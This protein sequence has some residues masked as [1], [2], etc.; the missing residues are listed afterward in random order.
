MW[1]SGN[2][3]SAWASF[4]SFF[5]HVAKLEIDY[6]KWD[7]WERGAIHAGPRIMHKEFCMI[8]DFPESLTVDAQNRPHNDTGP[9]CRWR[10]GSALYALHG[11]NVP[12]WVLETP[13]DQIDPK[14]VL[15]LEN[16]DQRAAIIRHIGVVE[17]LAHLQPKTLDKKDDYELLEV[18]I[19]YPE[20]RIYLR[21]S[22]PSEPKIHIEAVARECST[23]NEALMWR[24]FGDHKLPFVAPE[25][26]T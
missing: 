13:K 1:Q 19:G 21:M 24:N 14:K 16:V 18:S 25:V 9:F 26:L 3:W 20:P 11:V 2:Q 15:A 7:H 4:I 8:S 6:S 12:A 5:R 17:M 22:N 10:D 23:V